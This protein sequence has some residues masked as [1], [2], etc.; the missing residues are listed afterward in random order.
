[1]END[2]I[3]RL[4]GQLE[5][6]AGTLPGMHDP[7]ALCR[8]ASNPAQECVAEH[9]ARLAAEVGPANVVVSQAIQCGLDDLSDRN[10]RHTEGH[11]AQ[12]SPGDRAELMRR[13]RSCRQGVDVAALV[14]ARVKGGGTRLTPRPRLDIDAPLPL[15]PYGGVYG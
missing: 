2:F 15:G 3:H 6:Q 10:F 13:M 11:V 14:A 5:Q 12:H 8:L 7:R 1:M 9:A 4:G